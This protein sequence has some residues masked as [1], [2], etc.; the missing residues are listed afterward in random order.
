MDEK[1]ISFRKKTLKGG[2]ISF[3]GGAIDCVV[4]NKSET[5]ASL[6]VESNLG[7]PDQFTLLI[8]LENN[9]RECHVVGGAQKGWA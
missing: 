6:Q 5:G 9:K 4:R 1:R 8:K 2:T 7:I 3:G